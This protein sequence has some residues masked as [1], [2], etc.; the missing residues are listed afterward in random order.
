MKGIVMCLNESVHVEANGMVFPFEN[1]WLHSARKRRG[2]RP[3]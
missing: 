3:I 1:R 2:S